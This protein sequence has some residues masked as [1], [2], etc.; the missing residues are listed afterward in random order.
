MLAI[1]LWIPV[2]VVGIGIPLLSDEKFLLWFHIWFMIRRKKV[3]G[4]EAT[5]LWLP[6]NHKCSFLLFI[7]VL[8][9]SSWLLHHPCCVC[10][11]SECSRVCC[12]WMV[13]VRSR[14]PKSLLLVSRRLEMVQIQLNLS[15]FHM[16]ITSFACPRSSKLKLVASPNSFSSHYRSSQGKFCS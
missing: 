10:E 9:V 11:W 6:C 1:C 14:W 15:G 12:L 13:L 2:A 7:S 8:V 4:K 3:C 5:A 16:Q